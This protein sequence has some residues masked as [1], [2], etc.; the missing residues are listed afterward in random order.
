MTIEIDT[1]LE[2]AALA[3]RLAK[4]QINDEIRQ[5]PTPVAG[6]DV[7]YNALLSKRTQIS[8]ALEALQS[9]VF[10]PTPRTLTEGSGVESR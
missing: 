6:C 1:H 9:D 3:L 7:Q 8:K 5:Y 4:Q 10:V 2:A